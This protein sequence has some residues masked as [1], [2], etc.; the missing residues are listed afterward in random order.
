[1]AQDRKP[2]DTPRPSGRETAAESGE[3]AKRQENERRDDARH[4]ASQEE[5]DEAIFREAGNMQ[6]HDE[7]D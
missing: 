5:M 6:G 7:R 2:T 4:R 3:E 1:M